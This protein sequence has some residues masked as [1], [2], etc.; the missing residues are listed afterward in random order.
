MSSRSESSPAMSSRFARPV[1][2]RRGRRLTRE[3]KA[4]YAMRDHMRTRDIVW[5]V[6]AIPLLALVCFL[7][8]VKLHWLSDEPWM[9][10]GGA[11]A[12]G[13]ITF[14]VGRRWFVLAVLIVLGL[15]V[16]L[17]EDLPDIGDLGSGS[18][19]RKEARRRKLQRAIAKREALLQTNGSLAL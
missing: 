11:L 12:A 4:L 9:A 10:I 3:L 7:V 14:A 18:E 17:F 1:S 16:I 6:L 5:A 2:E 13:A 8:G 15:L 19:D